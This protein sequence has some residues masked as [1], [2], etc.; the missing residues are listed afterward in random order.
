MMLWLVLIHRF[1]WFP[2]AVV[3]WPAWQGFTGE[4]L[5]WLIVY[6]LLAALSCTMIDFF[7]LDVASHGDSKVGNFVSVVLFTLFR[8]TYYAPVASVCFFG[9]ALLRN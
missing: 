3:I 8:L 9:A 4:D 6:I 7:V 5:I 1:L 2:L